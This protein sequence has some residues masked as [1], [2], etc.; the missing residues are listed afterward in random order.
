MYRLVGVVEYG[1]RLHVVAATFSATRYPVPPALAKQYMSRLE[2]L[3]SRI[4]SREYGYVDIDAYTYVV[5]ARRFTRSVRGGISTDTGYSVA[6]LYVPYRL[7]EV[8]LPRVLC[9]LYSNRCK[10][11]GHGTRH[12]MCMLAHLFCRWTTQ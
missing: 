1:D 5:V 3:V 4:V 7:L 9:N 12:S 10:Y 2:A 6:R 11:D 8:L